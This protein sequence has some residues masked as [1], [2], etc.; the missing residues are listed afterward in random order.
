MTRSNPEKHGLHPPG[1]GILKVNF[2]ARS[3]TTF[4][5]GVLDDAVSLTSRLAV[6][7]EMGEAA[8][9]LEAPFLEAAACFAPPFFAAPFF[10]AVLVAIEMFLLGGQGIAQL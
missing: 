5:K 4:L 9:L 3:S 2:F 8:A 7:I 6:G 1:P 10:V